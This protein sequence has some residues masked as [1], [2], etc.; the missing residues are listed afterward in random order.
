MGA[1]REPEVLVI[2]AGPVGLT[3]ALAL[4]RHGIRVRIV[5][6]Q[7]RTGAHSYAL[8]LHRSS[9]RLLE[10]LG[11]NVRRHGLPI[12]SLAIYEGGRLRAELAMPPAT[13]GCPALLVLRQD[14]LESLL[15][16]AL[17]HHDLLVFWNHEVTEL[18]ADRNS[19]RATIDR[20]EK[21][22]MGY[23]VA[24][25]EWVVASTS[26]LQT[27]LVLAADGH[28]SAARRGLGI[29]F[30]QL[31]PAAYYAVFE[32]S[33]R[34]PLPNQVQ[35]VLGEGTTDVLWPMPDSR[36]R[37]SFQVP[38]DTAKHAL[39]VKDRLAV[40]VGEDAFPLLSEQ[41]FRE[42]LSQRAPWFKAAIEEVHWRITVRFE[43]RRA[44]SLGRGRIWLAGDAAHITSP[45]GMRSMN[46][47]I[48]EAC[49]LAGA[50]AKIL[51][52]DRPLNLLQEYDRNSLPERQA[53]SVL[54]GQTQVGTGA[55]DWVRRQPAAVLDCL[56]ASGGDLTQLAGQ[57]GLISIVKESL[58]QR[59]D[60]PH[61]DGTC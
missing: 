60:A 49:E 42:L 29:D 58:A 21:Q 7:W 14:V 9:V 3:G 52:D 35:I 11:V 40:H 13:D 36:C 20:R 15:E 23:A 28:R 27:P 41:H 5:D 59:A 47:G 30:P 33:C 48:R 32:C 39:R 57:L 55:P 37:W 54:D 22:S 2:G 56:P 8:A 19:V 25:T 46:A 51:R 4:T 17:R 38:E 61:R 16:L 43:R 45:A 34:Q 10:E 6:S 53:L 24:R 26:T 1:A 18:A 31:A 44:E 12:D 50:F